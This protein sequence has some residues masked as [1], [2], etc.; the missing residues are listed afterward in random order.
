MLNCPGFLLV[1]VFL[2]MYSPPKYE[3]IEDRISVSY[4]SVHLASRRV[5]G[6]DI[7]V[8]NEQIHF[9]MNE[10]GLSAGVTVTAS[11]Y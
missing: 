4:A 6:R 8:M 11:V 2:L 10:C 1:L 3:L 7:S 9:R 5:L